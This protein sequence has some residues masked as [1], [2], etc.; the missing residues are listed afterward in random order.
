[1]TLTGKTFRGNFDAP[2]IAVGA[3][4]AQVDE[5][6]KS[7]VIAI[8]AKELS[9]VACNYALNGRELLTQVRCNFLTFSNA[10]LYDQ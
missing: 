5:T 6:G 10:I 3:T 9:L 1:M 7:K 2:Q 8:L 4:L